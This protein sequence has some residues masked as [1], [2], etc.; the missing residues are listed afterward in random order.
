MNRRMNRIYETLMNGLEKERKIEENDFVHG[1]IIT[2][3]FVRLFA[4]ESY[5]IGSGGGRR[6]QQGEKNER[7]PY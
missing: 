7:H 6:N 3:F 4:R 5:H 1:W 2:K